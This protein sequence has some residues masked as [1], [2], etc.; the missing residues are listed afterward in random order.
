MRKYV[1]VMSDGIFWHVEISIQ[2]STGSCSLSTIIY[3][4]RDRISQFSAV[5]ST[6]ATLKQMPCII[7]LQSHNSY[8]MD[9]LYAIFRD[10]RGNVY[11]MLSL[12]DVSFVLC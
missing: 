10:S 8:K 4:L 12:H 3:S 1:F 7:Y 5:L 6:E 2:A 11:L 9:I